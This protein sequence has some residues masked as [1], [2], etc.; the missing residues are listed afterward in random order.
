VFS[1]GVPSSWRDLTSDE[2]LSQSALA[3]ARVALG[4]CLTTPDPRL[5]CPA[6]HFTVVDRGPG[7]AG[8]DA[9]M[10]F[11]DLDQMVQARVQALPDFSSYGAPWR[12]G[13]DGERAFVHHIIGSLPGDHFGVDQRVA[14]MGAEVS[15]VH[16]TTLYVG[17]FSSPTETY[18][19]YLPQFWTMLG[20]W[21]WLAHHQ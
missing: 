7:S 6:T 12:I 3:K 4:I 9:Q 8:P 18:E 2:L 17:M 21:R 20:S 10:M 15:V 13:L 5:G 14:T 11:V 1:V 19:S 16:G